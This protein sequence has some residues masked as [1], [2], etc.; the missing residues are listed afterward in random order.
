MFEIDDTIVPGT[1]FVIAF[2]PNLEQRE[3]CSEKPKYDPTSI[4]F[5]NI[6]K[7]KFTLNSAVPTVVIELTDEDVTGE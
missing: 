1:R 3:Y 4:R 6:D 2:G 7:R 5:E